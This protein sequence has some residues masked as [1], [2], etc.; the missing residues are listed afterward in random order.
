MPAIVTQR[1]SWHHVSDGTCHGSM[2]APAQCECQ[3][4]RLTLI[5]LLRDR[6]MIEFELLRDLEGGV[7]PNFWSRGN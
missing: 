4:R 5:Q 7:D 2:A 6:Q 3:G 1:M